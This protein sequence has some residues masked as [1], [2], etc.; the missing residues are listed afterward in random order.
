MNCADCRAIVDGDIK[1]CKACIA[2]RALSISDIDSE[3]KGWLTSDIIAARSHGGANPSKGEIEHVR[4]N[5]VDSGGAAD[6]GVASGVLAGAKA[7][8]SNA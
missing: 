5:A 2:V 8:V 7:E 3:Y 6:A 4:D 1:R